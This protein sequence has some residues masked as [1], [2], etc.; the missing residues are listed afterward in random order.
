MAVT[1]MAN[2]DGEEEEFE[3]GWDAIWKWTLD[4]L[5]TLLSYPYPC[6]P[7]G[8]GVGFA[9]GKGGGMALGTQGFTPAIP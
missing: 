3:D 9:R 2:V 5:D 8:W 1:V 6:L 7:L 4:T